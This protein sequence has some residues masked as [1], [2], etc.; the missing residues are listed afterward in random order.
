MHCLNVNEARHT[1]TLDDSQLYVITLNN[2]TGF[3]LFIAQ[4]I[5]LTCRFRAKRYLTYLHLAKLT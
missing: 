5:H 2:Q 4:I 3:M 1:L